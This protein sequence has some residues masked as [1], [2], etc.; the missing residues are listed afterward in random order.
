MQTQPH[1]SL[2]TVL[3]GAVLALAVAAP[4]ASAAEPPNFP[5]AVPAQPGAP[6][7]PTAETS[8][9]RAQERYLTSYGD[10]KPLA[11]VSEPVDDGGVDW[12]SIGIVVGGTVLLLGAVVPLLMRTRRRSGRVRITA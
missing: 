6:T 10:P 1:T 2:V 11:Q 7:G 8:A 9:A 4:A 12:T 5:T 3:I